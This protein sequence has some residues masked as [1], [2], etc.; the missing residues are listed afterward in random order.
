MCIVY[1][2]DSKFVLRFL[3]TLQEVLDS[4][5][6]FI[7]VYHP[8][9]YGQMKRTNQTLE[10]MLRACILDFGSQWDEGLLLCEFACNNGFHSSTGMT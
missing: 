7:T 10:N 9:T 4:N 3:A 5:L 2:R 8:E 6:N 1:D